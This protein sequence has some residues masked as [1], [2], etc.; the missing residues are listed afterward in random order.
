MIFAGFAVGALLGAVIGVLWARQ[1]A[2]QGRL[3]LER[4]V[5]RLQ[6][7]SRAALEVVS[8]VRGQF[9]SVA[10]GLAADLTQKS[11][12]VLLV[13][14]AESLRGILDP[15][16]EKLSTFEKKVEEGRVQES[17]EI[18]ILQHEI[19]RLA[20]LNSHIATEA[21]NLT[22]ALRGDVKLQGTWGEMILEKVLETSGLRDGIEYSRQSTGLGLRSEQGDR[23]M[24][25]VVV[26]L[27]DQRHLV[28]DSKVSLKAYEQWSQAAE[29][30]KKSTFLQQH[31]ES[32]TRHIRDLSEKSYWYNEALLSPDYVMLFV[33]V[34]GA[35]A[36]ALG[37]KPELFQLAW[38]K[39]VVLVSPT[40]L[41]GVL[42][43]VE[44][45]WRQEKQT[46]N[47][48][49]IAR[50]GGALYDDFVRLLEELG[51]VEKG[52]KDA[53]DA[54]QL[55]VKR[56]SSG[57]GNLLSRVETLRELGARAKKQIPP[58]SLGAIE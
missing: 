56:I 49:E 30:E 51:G 25:D 57:R 15:F 44:S 33:P 6:G 52:V 32:L 4:E 54:H 21:N 24:P 27:P 55:L 14:Q 40:T 13:S 10:Q 43:T 48:I 28:I 12:D 23:V 16:R 47:A 2:V 9:E 11:R 17:R 5:G 46:K 42:K 41:L 31:V 26:H 29:A 37:A 38:D 19:K 58:S 18:G 35:F 45:L 20:D 1:Q 8:Q 22:Q 53:L 34:E 3:H 7:E 36:A 39:R 50:V